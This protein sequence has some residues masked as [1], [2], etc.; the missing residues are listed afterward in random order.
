M[1]WTKRT[2]DQRSVLKELQGDVLAIKMM[3]QTIKDLADKDQQVR[4]DALLWLV[5]NEVWDVCD[6]FGI[7]EVIASEFIRITYMVALEDTGVR[8]KKAANDGVKEF[9]RLIIEGCR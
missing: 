6:R 2:L 9:K 7:S 5:K 3:E 1:A 8:R 4:E